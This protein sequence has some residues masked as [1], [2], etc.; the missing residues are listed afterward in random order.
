[1]SVMRLMSDDVM[2]GSLGLMWFDVKYC[3]IVKL[4]FVMSVVG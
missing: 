1:M 4:L 3:V 2:F